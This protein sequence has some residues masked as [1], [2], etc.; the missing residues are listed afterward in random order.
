MQRRLVDLGRDYGRL[1]AMQRLSW[2]IN[3]EG[4]TFVEAAFRTSLRFAAN[5]RMVW[6]YE[7]HE[8]VVGWLWIDLVDSRTC[9]IRHLQV[10][11]DY[12]GQG[13]GREILDDAAVLCA[14]HGRSVVTLTVT[15]SNERAM[16]LYTNA[17][18]V[19]EE[20][21]GLRQSM[22]LETERVLKPERQGG[23]SNG[24]RETS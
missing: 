24:H 22:K 20:D 8:R 17:G 23:G 13:V 15:K 7:R 11:K 1:L 5:R 6:V 19:L 2:Q 21:L 18:Y 9:H 14:E 4:R 12:W 3:F 16:A 10:E